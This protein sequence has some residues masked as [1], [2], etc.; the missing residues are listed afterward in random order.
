[1]LK[2][3]VPVFTDSDLKAL[4]NCL[5]Y[6]A[7]QPVE[8]LLVLHGP[9]VGVVNAQT[10]A[11]YDQRIANLGTRKKELTLVEDFA[12][13]QK[14]KEEIETLKVERDMAIREGWQKIPEAERA[15]MYKKAFGDI[16]TEPIC[17]REA[18]QHDQVFSMLQAFLPQWPSDIPHGEYSLVW[19]RSVPTTLE[20]PLRRPYDGPRVKDVMKAM[21]ESGNVFPHGAGEVTERGKRGAHLKSLHHLQVFRIGR[22]AGIQ[23]EGLKTPAV[24]EAILDKEFPP[25][26]AAAA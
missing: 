18:Y 3:I 25:K 16:G 9:N 21:A 1:M 8:T 24:I 26:Q 12:G 23:V 17:L 13:A 15:A 19:P 10:A 7:Q 11:E 2:V 22:D 20:I 14:A 5:R 6:L 4:P